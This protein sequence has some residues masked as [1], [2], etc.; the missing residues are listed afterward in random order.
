MRI[1]SKYRDYYDA[2]MGEGQDR[3][4]VFVRH[5]EIW[6][7]QQNQVPPATLKPFLDYLSATR[8]GSVNVRRLP[9]A[10]LTDLNLY[11]GAIWLAGRFYPFATL[12]VREVKNILPNDPQFFYDFDSLQQ[13]T[14]ALGY[15]ISE[16]ASNRFGRAP[17]APARSFFE[18]SGSDRLVPAAYEH[19]VGLASAFGS[20]VQLNP[21]LQDF[22]FFRKLNP[23]E[24]Y[25]ELSMFWGN[26]AHPDMV[27]V[28]LSEKDRI[29][30]H[31][32]DKWSFR[33]R[34][35]VA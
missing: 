20:R 8:P 2:G 23:W 10:G 29:N 9:V 16:K 17:R 31:G 6:D 19:R 13:A 3:S 22:E 15:E 30:Q 7:L 18:L 1:I 14:A 26:V 21:R 5:L 24:A 33:R 28:T 35:A 25:Q 32:Y 27:P 11:F 34:P 12:S 4:L